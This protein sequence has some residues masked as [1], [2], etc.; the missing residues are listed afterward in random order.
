MIA[1]WIDLPMIVRLLTL[2]VVGALSGALAN[3]VIYSGCYFPRPI[4]PWGKPAEDA[5]DRKTSDRFPVIGWLGLAR[6]SSIHGRGF[7]V[8]PMLIEIGLAIALPTLYW[9]ETQTGGL[10]PGVFRVAATITTFEPWNTRI[11][12][13]HAALL[14]LMT[15]ATFIDFDEQ[16]IPDLITIPGTILGLMF[17]SISVW[18]SC[19]RS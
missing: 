4:S 7:W 5:A 19:P 15:A 12:F 13:A 6:E 9:M 2:G 18:D 17:A 8:R 11:F 1:F 3:H 14:L 16:T 10:W